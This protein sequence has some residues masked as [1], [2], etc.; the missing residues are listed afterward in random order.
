VGY[1]R[2]DGVKAL[3]QMGLKVY[4]TIDGETAEVKAGDSLKVMLKAAGTTATVR[5][6]DAAVHTVAAKVENLRFVRV[7]GALQVGFDVD[8][9][10]AGAG[11]QVQLVG[12]HGKVLASARG[13]SA[14]GRN[15]LAL[16]APKPGLYLLRVTVGGNHAVRKVAI[17]R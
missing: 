11:Y 13:K 2:F 5:V 6:T 7:S 14:A 9:A 4:V 1:L 8:D 10:L 12:V 15:T 16:K 17:Q 3:N